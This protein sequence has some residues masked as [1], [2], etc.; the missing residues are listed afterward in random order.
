M[1]LDNYCVF[2]NFIMLFI[3]RSY[4]IC[5]NPFNFFDNVLWNFYLCFVK[6][7]ECYYMR[8]NDNHI[9]EYKNELNQIIYKIQPSHILIYS[10]LN[11]CLWLSYVFLKIYIV[12]IQNLYNF[13]SVFLGTH[14]FIL[15]RYN[16]ILRYQTW[17]YLY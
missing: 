5:F 16:Q 9:I 3:I 15:G 12:R 11:F 10:N 1:Q 13:D 17:N 8:Y 6:V 7:R 4:R 14:G 2:I